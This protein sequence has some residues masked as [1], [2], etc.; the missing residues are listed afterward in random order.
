MGRVI[1]NSPY[2][3]VY[4]K[5]AEAPVEYHTK[6]QYKKKVFGVRKYELIEELV[7]TFDQ[8]DFRDGEYIDFYIDKNAKKP[9]RFYLD[10][11]T[12]HWYEMDERLDKPADLKEIY[13]IVYMPEKQFLDVDYYTDEVN[14]NNLIASTTWGLTIDELEPGHSY[15]I[16]DILPN[17]YINKFKPVRCNGGMVQNADVKYT[18]ETLI[19]QGHI[20]IVYK[21]LVEPDDPT[22]AY[23]E[24][25]VLGFGSFRAAIPWD[26]QE[27]RH[28]A[29]GG[30]I[31][32]IDLGYRPKE[33]G[34][35]KV[36]IKGIA[37]ANGLLGSA[38][39]GGWQDT[40]YVDFFGYR[41]PRDP[42][43]LGDLSHNENEYITEDDLG[44]FYSSFIANTK[45]GHFSFSTRV[46]ESS[47]WVYTAEGPQ[48]LDGQTLYTAAAGAG[49]ISGSP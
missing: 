4:T 9:E 32:Y 14:E 44:N 26:A 42:V 34:R 25:K 19:D 47:G 7:L 46:P 38:C 24:P 8:S 30:T 35:L 12:Y 48:F 5:M 6:V 2:N 41:V 49:V 10:G 18:F 13:E 43:S 23:Y 3:I 20:D 36:E 45:K 28:L 11:V 21:T 22:Q 16:V 33:L 15:S 27:S 37:Q 39:S 29:H 40:S 1:D 17:S 31:P